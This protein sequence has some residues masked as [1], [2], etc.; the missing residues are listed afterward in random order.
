MLHAKPA[1]RRKKESLLMHP[2]ILTTSLMSTV[3]ALVTLTS[4][5]ATDLPVAEYGIG[6]WETNGHSNHR[7]VLAVTDPAVAVKAIIPGRR[8][9]ADP[10]TKAVLLFN[11]KGEPIKNVK[12]LSLTKDQGEVLFEAATVGK[13]FLHSPSHS[14]KSFL[15]FSSVRFQENSPARNP[16]K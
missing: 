6:S 5:A 9:N 2:R 1:K 10:E 11:E 12:V 15:L 3:L 13:Y 8:R 7:T 14:A 16:P 4:H